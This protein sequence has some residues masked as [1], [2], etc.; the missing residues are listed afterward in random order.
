MLVKQGYTSAYIAR[1]V[2]DANGW[3]NPETVQTLESKLTPGTGITINDDDVIS[4]PAIPTTTPTTQGN[5]TLRCSVDSSGN[6]TY[7]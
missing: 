3:H 6:A 7:S 5:Y 4:V 1:V 2:L